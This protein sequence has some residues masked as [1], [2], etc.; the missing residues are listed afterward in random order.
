MTRDEMLTQFA[1]LLDLDASALIGYANED[2]LGGFNFDASQSKWP[3]GS[4]WEVEG[5]T[6]YALVR[7]LKPT[8]VLELGTHRGCSTSH[9]AAAV[10]RNVHLKEWRKGNVIAVDVWEGAGDLIPADL[11]EVVEQRFADAVDVIHSLPDNSVQ[12]VF[13]DLLHGSEQV[14]AVIE[15]L[16]PKLTS[17]AVVVH[18]DSEHGE[19]GVKVRRGIELAGIT[20]YVSLLAA[21]SDC[22]LAV[23]RGE[24][25]GDAT[26]FTS[27]IPLKKMETYTADGTREE[28][29]LP[30]TKKPAAKRTP[31]K[32]ATHRKTAAK[33]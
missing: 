9:L 33:K 18:H 19:D 16:K 2:K 22:G 10:L 23:W 32:K 6:L 20:K 1:A 11:R 24:A 27:D 29:T 17:H 31:A 25:K 4:L 26:Q 3:G 13:E 8:T 14:A 30:P 15:A 7:A 5:Q 28:P 12:F 21:P